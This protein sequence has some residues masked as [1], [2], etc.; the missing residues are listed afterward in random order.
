V[1]RGEYQGEKIRIDMSRYDV[2]VVG[3]G[4]NGL[5]CAAYLG[6]AGRRVLVL[7]AAGQ[8]GGAAITR[9]IAD[10]CRVSACAHLLYPM[11]AR[12]AA[13]LQLEKFGLRR[14][15]TDLKTIALDTGGAHLVIDGERLAGG[16]IRPPDVAALPPFLRRL[17]RFAA[18]LENTYQRPPPR[19]ASGSLRDITALARLALSVRLLG[20]DDMRE[21]LRIGAMNVY[22]LLNE[23]FESEALKGALA[24]DAV[25]GTRL[26]PRSPNSVLTLLHRLV[27]CRDGSGSGLSL[28]AG[29]MGA[30]SSAL[31]AAAQAAGVEIRAG[32]P[33]GSIET[34]NGRAVGVRIAD[35]SKVAAEAVVSNADPRTTFLKLVGAR[36]LEAGFVR[37]IGNIRMQGS[38]AKLHLLLEGVPQFR[39]LDPGLAG[40]RL[41]VAPSMTYLEQAFDHCKYAEDPP[42]PAMEAIIPS[43]HDPALA[44]PGRHVLSAIVQY[45]SYIQGTGEAAVLRDNAIRCL[46]ELAPDIRAQIV[47]AELLAPAD[48]E[49]QFRMTGGHWHHGE[50]A[51]DQFMMLRP[52]PGTARYAT[53]IAGLYLCGAGAHPGGGIMGLAGRNAADA[54]IRGGRPA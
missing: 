29:G 19:L 37:R 54:V 30:V 4:H 9:E 3:G 31:A 7:E 46:E 15:A 16:G 28:P 45:A 52:V 34:A 18:I 44:P 39:G 38:V 23:E 43:L 2:I 20:R 36:S 22:D 1:I 5:V 27:G 21:L 11:H 17:R 33:V 24:F 42:Q 12:V 53:P 32:C 14:A 13:D 6:R 41:L 48:L 26:G 10:G 47:K 50:L 49:R 40:H 25:M 35:G 51:L 8:V